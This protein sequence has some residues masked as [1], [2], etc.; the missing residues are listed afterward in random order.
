[1]KLIPKII[2]Q[3]EGHV[4]TLEECRR[5][6]EIVAI[7]DPDS[8]GLN[9]T[10]PDDDLLLGYLDGAVEMAEAFTGLSIALRTY[11]VALSSFP[12][13]IS[14]CPPRVAS[15]PIEI[16][17]P[18][19]VEVISFQSND[20]SDGPMDSAS[21]VIDDYGIVP[22]VRPVA[23]WPASDGMVNGIKLRYRAGYSSEDSDAQPLPKLIKQAILMTVAYWY[24]NREDQEDLTQQAKLLLRPLRIRLGMA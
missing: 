6:C 24:E 20:G 9:Q 10:H 3:A 8:D 22:L 7:D 19:L 18:P 1:M 16:P 5:Q 4:L 2:V 12:R 13:W 21:Y 14:G 17:N 23:A 11:E 15:A